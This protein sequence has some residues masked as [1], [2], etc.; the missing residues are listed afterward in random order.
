M[1]GEIVAAIVLGLVEGLTE[2]IPVSSTGHL[3][4]AD[5]VLGQSG[6]A[7]GVLD[8]VIQVGAILAV[9]WVYRVRLWNVAIGALRRERDALHFCAMVALGVFP[10]IVIGFLAHD[11]IKAVLFSPWVVAISLIVGGLAILIVE[12]WRREPGSGGTVSRM[13]WR[14]A[15][16]IGL[17]QLLA[18]IPGVSRSGATIIGGIAL[19]ADRRLATEFSFFLAIPTMFGA[20][21]LDLAKSHAALTRADAFAI[22]LATLAAFL[23]AMVVIRWLIRFVADHDFRGFAWYRLA[24]GAVAIVLLKASAQ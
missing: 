7:V 3:I 6:E 21:A 13:S 20:A 12:R 24:A 5:R 4:L 19:G 2:F 8:V 1:T 22:A 16:G 10:S 14:L 23:V 9:C 18:M 15:L 17:C 11:F